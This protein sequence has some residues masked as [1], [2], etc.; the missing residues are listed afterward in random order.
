MRTKLIFAFLL[1]T[2]L[3]GEPAHVEGGAFMAFAATVRPV[4]V[5]IYFR[6]PYA[7]PPKCIVSAG[8]VE[9]TEKQYVQILTQVGER[10]VWECRE[11]T[12]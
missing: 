11:K 9:N 4:G 10:V 7:K 3:R 5:Q 2:S 6:S 8:E 1:A 12:R